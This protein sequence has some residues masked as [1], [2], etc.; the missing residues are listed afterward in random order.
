MI[1]I[2]LCFHDKL[3]PLFCTSQV[4]AGCAFADDW[5]FN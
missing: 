4:S 2:N 3:N 5:E 1:N